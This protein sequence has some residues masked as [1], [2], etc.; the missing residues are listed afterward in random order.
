MDEQE[1]P[2]T[3]VTMA[4]RFRW[5]G[6]VYETVTDATYG[7]LMAC[8]RWLEQPA[9]LW[10]GVT[11]AM[12]AQFISIRRGQL[13]AG[14]PLIGLTEFRDSV[15]PNSITDVWDEMP[16][17]PAPEDVEVPDP[18]GGA[19]QTAESTRRVRPARKGSASAA[20]GT[21]SGSPKRSGGTRGK[22]TT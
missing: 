2:G 6:D 8:E 9:E 22:S 11:A 15:G 19:A 18:L 13:A 5:R 17:A 1:Q 20:R 7:E 21:S 16:A 10:S 14:R 3:E 4:S 12:V